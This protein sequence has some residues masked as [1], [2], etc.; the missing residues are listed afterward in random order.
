MQ[1]LKYDKGT[2]SVVVFGT[3]CHWGR[4]SRRR[5]MLH[6]ILP[7]NLPIRTGMKIVVEVTKVPYRCECKV[8]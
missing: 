8:R 6:A 4:I 5:H 3:I 2:R 7:S 1:E